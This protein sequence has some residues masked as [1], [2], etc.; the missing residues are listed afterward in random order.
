MQSPD[1]TGACHLSGRA[2]CA[3]RSE[4]NALS[5]G[6]PAY[7]PEN[8]TLKSWRS[9]KAGILMLALLLCAA[10]RG[11]RSMRAAGA[12]QVPKVGDVPPLVLWAWEEPEDLRNVDAHRVGVAFL[13]ERVFIGKTVHTISRRQRLLVPTGIWAEAVVRIEGEPTFVDSENS[14]RRAADAVLRA[15]GLPGVRGVQVDFDATVSQRT[16]YADVLQQV[17]ARLPAGD[18]LEM[19]ALVSWCSQN[20][21]WMHGL[22]VDAAVP[23]DFRLGRHVGIW[24]VREPLC[25]GSIGISTDEPQPPLE[26][27][28]AR[29]TY[30]FAQGPWTASQVAEINKGRIPQERR[31]S[32]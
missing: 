18:R 28:S 21:G 30:V 29:T 4:C 3:R 5:S 19:T 6:R 20:D 2:V 10:M 22:P 25:A 12:V 11:D 32:R 13:A 7:V 23:M 31:G 9:K 26:L 8:L 14:R 1:A 24:R 27:R 15:A 16:F 17:R